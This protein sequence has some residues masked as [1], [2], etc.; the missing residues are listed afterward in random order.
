ME[1]AAKHQIQIQ[2]I[3]PGNPQQNAYVERFNHTVR[4]EWISQHYWQSIDEV[5]MFA[6][7]LMCQYNHQ[8]PNMALDA[9]T[10]K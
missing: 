10:P 1:W 6:T 5:Q 9:F 4:Y 2:H 8:S 3:Q 7:Q